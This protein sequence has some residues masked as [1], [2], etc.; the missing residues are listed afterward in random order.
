MKNNLCEKIFISSFDKSYSSKVN[1]ISPEKYS[2]LEKPIENFSSLITMGSNL[3]YSPV[4]FYQ[5]SISISL[6]K[7]N[8]ILN[9]NNKKKEVTIEAGARIFDLLSYL[10]PKG[11]WIPQLPGHPYITIGGAVAAN[12]Q[13]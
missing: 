10:L 3:S 6:I 4:S 5:K 12:V 9:F 8:K 11:L 1:F 13:W 2:D 7:F